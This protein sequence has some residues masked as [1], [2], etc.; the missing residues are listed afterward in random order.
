MTGRC[1]G[2][3]VALVGC[4][5]FCAGA[6]VLSGEPGEE[7]SWVS[8]LLKSLEVSGYVESSY[9]WN[10]AS[11]KPPPGEP[12][13]RN[14]LFDVRSNEFSLH[15]ATVSVAL[16]VGEDRWVG[17]RVTP[18]VGQD[19]EF[20][21]AAGLFRDES[22][23]SESKLD[24]LDAYIQGYCPVT[25]TRLVL[26]KWQTTAGAEVIRGP[27]NDNFSRSY[28]FSYAVPF[29]HTG[30]FA[31]QP[32]LDRPSDGAEL[33][34]FGAAVTNGWDNVRDDNDSKALHAV[35][36]FTPCDPF[37]LAAT[38]IFSFSEQ[39]GVKDAPRQLVDVVATIRPVPDLKLVGNFDWGRESEA[40]GGRDAVWWGF[41]GSAR[42]DFSP[43][44]KEKRDW[45]VAVRGEYFDDADGA[46]LPWGG[47][48]GTRVWEVTATL[49]YTPFE[50]L[51][52]RAELRYDK[53]HLPIFFDG[54]DRK[55]THQTTLAFEAAFL[56]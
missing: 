32:V 55:D 16:P 42:Y 54:S 40:V 5:A 7:G 13:N 35:A 44:G 51:L 23:V 37:S 9:V 56:F 8:G 45:Y 29:T 50:Y 20:V 26:G 11:P 18:F 22:G 6:R 4:A 21:Q 3:R 15:A 31:Q 41:A 52:L 28:L 46:R 43:T 36:S 24:L 19:A 1:L 47:P 10:P 27:Y 25:R 48:G 34:A 30:I 38:Y 39:P 33:L 2:A 14:R 17:F 12:E 53:A 49:G